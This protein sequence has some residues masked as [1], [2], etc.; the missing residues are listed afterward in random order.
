[1]K[2]PI[3]RNQAPLM[4]P[5]LRSLSQA[6]L[7]LAALPA[8][9]AFAQAAP[10]AGQLIQQ[11]PAPQA[12]APSSRPNLNVQQPPA[13][14][15]ASSAPFLVRSIQV[16]GNTV[17][18]TATL[19]SLVA[20]GEGKTITLGQLDALANRITQYY[21]DRGYPL[22]RAIIPAQTLSNG[23]VQ[24][25][26]LE[27]RYGQVKLNN[28]SRASNATLGSV[29]SPLQAG[30]LLSQASLD[31][32]LLLLSDYPG[33]AV[34]ATLSPGQ[35]V[36]TTDLTVNA[37]ATQ[38]FA[39]NVFFDTYGSKYTGRGRL[40]AN[41]Q[42]NNL[43]GR[44]DQVTL[45]GL[46]SMA[47]L[48][49]ARGAYQMPING[50]GTQVGAAFSA[51]RY[52]L[53]DSLKP[54][55]AHGNASIASLWVSH[56]VVRSIDRNLY[57]RAGY[58]HKEFEDQIDTTG[59]DNERYSNS[60]SLEAS[61]DVRDSLFGGAISTASLGVT[62]GRLNFRN[63]AAKAADAATAKT[64]GSFSKLTANVARTQ[65]ITPSSTLYLGVAGQWSNDNLDASEQIVLGGP[66]SV[67]GYGVGT[68]SGATG[69]I[70]T[71]EFRQRLP[72]FQSAGTLQ[73]IAFVDTG[74]TKVYANTFAAGPNTARLNGAGIG[75]NWVA[76]EGWN[77]K[78]DIAKPFGSTPALLGSRD[79]F[80]AW[81]QVG[82]SF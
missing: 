15:R 23:T 43:L 55:G 71:A 34:N 33:V 9:Q 80:W 38:R 28:T 30:Q 22:T 40:G 20:D 64:A 77:A 66:S 18:P 48:D 82:K 70:G 67:R 51:L 52:R 8:S 25:Q 50:Q 72:V 1:M 13:A 41:L 81:V 46:T 47:G 36:G 78:I 35:N 76:T 27:T 54:V 68:V 62:A 75:L 24:L 53:G 49:Y 5:L 45:T 60:L 44:G 56:P 29:L 4:K 59:L 7:V 11:V 26:V 39:G 74:W 21:R 58:D 6:T 3:V 73:A 31:R 17:F 37:T 19:H 57:L 65:S 10:G 63:A 14:A 61:G 12:P 42:A 79:N 16:T 32:A 2:N 69:Y